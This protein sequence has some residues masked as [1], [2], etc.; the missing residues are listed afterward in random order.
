MCSLECMCACKPGFGTCMC[1]VLCCQSPLP[2]VQSASLLAEANR[3]EQ[4]SHVLTRSRCCAA[5]LL[6]LC[7]TTMPINS[8]S[9]HSL[10]EHQGLYT[11]PAGAVFSS[12]QFAALLQILYGYGCLL[13]CCQTCVHLSTIR[14]PVGCSKHRQA[15]SA[16][17]AR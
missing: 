2:E 16:H 11:P 5:W 14:Q 8:M 17:S 7:G 3:F 1:T 4:Y 6:L 9:V 12:H 13:V 10:G 15:K